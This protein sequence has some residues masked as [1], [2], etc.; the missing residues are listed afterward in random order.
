MF[1]RSLYYHID[2]GLLVA[3]ILAL[4]GLGVA[5]I[6]S[7]TVRPDRRWHLAPAPRRSCRAIVLGLVAM[8]L[9]ARRHRLMR[10]PSPDKSR[11]LIYLDY[12]RRLLLY[13]MFLRHRADGARG[14]GSRSSCFN[15]QPSEVRE[16]RR[17]ARPSPKLLRRQPR[18]APTWSDLAIGG[19]TGLTLTCRSGAHR[20]NCHDLGTAVTAAADLPRDR[21]SGRHADAHPRRHRAVSRAVS[22]APVAGQ[23]T[24]EGLSEGPGSPRSSTRPRDAKETPELPAD[25]G[26]HHGR[27]QG[28]D[29]IRQ[30]FHE[31]ARQG[32]LRFLPV[33]HN[34]FIFSGAGRGAGILPASSWRFRLVSVR[35][36]ARARG[37]PSGARIGSARPRSLGVA[38]QLHLPGGLQHHHVGRAGTRQ[39]HHASVHELRRVVDDCDARRLRARAQRAHAQVAN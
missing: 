12:P 27:I 36:S 7:T 39:G 35:D 11:H 25:P 18:H 15:L 16:N 37:R 4:C 33:A 21:L 10:T 23:F 31:G 22:P 19:V 17:G 6:Y 38:R 28:R 20:A 9:H 14:A 13:V 32:Q 5:M 1:E 26:A 8:A 29:L 24:L 2:W 30:G 34:D 3:A